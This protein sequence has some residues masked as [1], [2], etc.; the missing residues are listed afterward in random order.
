MLIKII[1][2]SLFIVSVCFTDSAMSINYTSSH[3]I[4]NCSGRGTVDVIFHAYGHVQEAWLGNFEVGSGH[5]VSNGVDIVRFANGD[6]LFHA[7]K[8]DRYAFHY[9]MSDKTLN[10]CVV[11]AEKKPKPVNLLT[12][13]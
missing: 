4:L 1:R 13:R 10:P 6:I 3:L 11:V 2:L 12:V 9:I 5:R 8:I 7:Q